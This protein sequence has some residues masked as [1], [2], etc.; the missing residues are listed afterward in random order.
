MKKNYFVTGL[1][2]LAIGVLTAIVGGVLFYLLALLNLGSGS[3]L[4]S[5][6]LIVL[7]VLLYLFLG[8]FLAQKVW[9]W[10]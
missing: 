8:G 6:V 2:L 9:G 5:F 4:F 1:K 7:Y 10:K 3:S